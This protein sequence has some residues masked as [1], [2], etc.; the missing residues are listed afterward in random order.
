MAA[1]GIYLTGVCRACDKV[2]SGYGVCWV[3]LGGNIDKLQRVTDNIYRRD[4]ICKQLAA[5]QWMKSLGNE[6]PEIFPVAL[7]CSLSVS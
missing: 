3:R 7:L 2:C 4:N 5:I 6:N 1:N